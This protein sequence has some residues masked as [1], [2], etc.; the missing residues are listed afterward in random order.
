MVSNLAAELE[1]LCQ[2][3][4]EESW[5]VNENICD[6]YASENM[7][8]PSSCMGY[9]NVN[10]SVG[11]T[12]DITCSL[13]SCKTLGDAQGQFC[14]VDL[15]NLARQP[16]QDNED[17]YNPPDSAHE[18]HVTDGLIMETGSETSL[19]TGQVREHGG[20]AQET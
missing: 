17:S 20:Q 4:P 5:P 19:E 10:I 7:S 6:E 16:T 12:S 13:S 2:L 11:N 8:N 14:H 18:S 15:A 3:Y 9:G 1:E